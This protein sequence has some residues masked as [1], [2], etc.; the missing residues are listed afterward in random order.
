MAYLSSTGEA[1][2]SFTVTGTFPDQG[3][4]QGKEQG[5]DRASLSGGL[6]RVAAL[7]VHQEFSRFEDFVLPGRR[8]A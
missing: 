4:F 1:S 8:A 2:T 3:T 5:M 7:D 6:F